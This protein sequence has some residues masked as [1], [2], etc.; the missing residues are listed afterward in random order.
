MNYC[1]LI[2]KQAKLKNRDCVG[3]DWYKIGALIGIPT[4]VFLVIIISGNFLYKI[5]TK[6]HKEF[7]LNKQKYEESI[8]IEESINQSIEYE[9]FLEESINIEE[10]IKIEESLRQDKL[11]Q[12]EQQK[13]E[14]KIVKNQVPYGT[15]VRQKDTGIVGKVVNYQGDRIFTN[16]DFYFDL[17]KDLSYPDNIEEIGQKD[18]LYG[19][20]KMQK[21]RDKQTRKIAESTINEENEINTNYTKS[22]FKMV[23]G[24]DRYYFKVNEKYYRLKKIDGLNVYTKEGPVFNSKT[25]NIIEVGY[26]EFEFNNKKNR[27]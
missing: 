10:S 11:Q 26:M 16:T 18:Y 19:L 23:N 6:K 17:N 13:Y 20:N 2:K 4:V 8:K 15:W 3:L 1:K 22:L 9:K 7:L 25:D 14:D 5:G 24:Y 12:I 27:R 21:S